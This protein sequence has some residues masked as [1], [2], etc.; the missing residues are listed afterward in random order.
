MNSKRLFIVFWLGF[1]CVLQHEKR[2]NELAQ[3]KIFHAS[4]Q[5][6]THVLR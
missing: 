3:R 1:L 2:S 5:M 4:K 6:S